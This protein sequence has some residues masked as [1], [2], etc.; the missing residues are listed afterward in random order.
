MKKYFIVILLF[1]FSILYPEKVIHADSD[2]N[3]QVQVVPS[4]LQ[5]GQGE[6][7]FD[8]VVPPRKSTSIQLNL[9]N[10]SSS[11]VK[12]AISV[13]PATTDMSGKVAYGGRNGDGSLPEM[14]LAKYVKGPKTIVIPAKSTVTYK[15]T[16]EMPASNYAGIITG[17][18]VLQQE[19]AGSSPSNNSHN[20]LQVL[21][22]YRY[23]IALLARTSDTNWQPAEK[24]G[25]AIV[26]RSKKTVGIKVPITNTSNTF[27]NQLS[28]D[29]SVQKD[30]KKFV[31]H[32]DHMQMAP[33]SNFNYA[34]HLGSRVTTGTYQVMTKT[35]FVEDESGQYVDSKGTKYRYAVSKKQNVSVTSDQA[36]QLNKALQKNKHVFPS[37]FYIV[38]IILLLLMILVM[39]GGIFFW[40]GRKKQAAQIAELKAKISDKK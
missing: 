5:R 30:G 31:T 32:N 35:Y 23:V 36:N 11:T 21:S 10:T 1:G 24:I 6:A 17:G 33:N 40:R 25:T 16:I 27:L 3:F 9:K 15:A 14:N 18:I 39:V 29:T 28:I 2:M 20:S 26:A 19:T 12:V 34:V 8:L 4:K 38:G 7:Y 37:I 22:K 13:V